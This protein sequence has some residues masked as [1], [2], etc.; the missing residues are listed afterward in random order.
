MPVIPSV[1]SS[2]AISTGDCASLNIAK[3]SS[4]LLTNLDETPVRYTEAMAAGGTSD[5]GLKDEGTEPTS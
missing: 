3:I 1:S 5:V 4:V 2:L